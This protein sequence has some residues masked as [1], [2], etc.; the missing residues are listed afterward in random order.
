M[1]TKIFGKTMLIVLIGLMCLE[2]LVFGATYTATD[3]T[4]ILKEVATEQVGGDIGFVII[5]IGLALAGL[6]LITTK[7]FMISGLVLI[8]SIVF[9][10][11]PDLASGII[12]QFA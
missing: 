10:M 12:S 9:A 11:A 5:L 6:T 1:Q 7:N 2:T 4:G 8:G 3:A